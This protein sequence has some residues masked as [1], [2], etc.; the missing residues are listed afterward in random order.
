METVMH[1]KE[2][3]LQLKMPYPELNSIRSLW[4]Q[5]SKD[6]KGSFKGNLLTMLT[7]TAISILI[8]FFFTP[9]I[10]RL[11]TPDMYG[12]FS[13]FRAVSTN[14]SLL[15]PLGF[16]NALILPKEKDIFNA[17]LKIIII[18]ALSFLVLSYS[19]LGIGYLLNFTDSFQ[20]RMGYWIYF[21]PLF[22][23]VSVFSQVIQSWNARLK[24]FRR[25]SVASVAGILAGKSFTISKGLIA[26]S[27]AGLIIGETIFLLADIIIGLPKTFREFIS[28]LKK[29]SM[30]DLKDVFRSFSNYPKYV[31]PA[32][33]INLFGTQLPIFL[34]AFTQSSSTL[35]QLTFA[36]GIINIP[37][38]LISRSFAPVFLQKLV[39]STDKDDSY[40]A[41]LTSR[42]FKSIF[43]L[44]LL[45]FT[46]LLFFGDFILVTFLGDQ[47]YIAGSVAQILVYAFFLAVCTGPLSVI[48]RVKKRERVYF[49]L[50]T[51]SVVLCAAGY[52]IGIYI[53][54][55]W[56]SIIGM[57]AGMVLSNM[58]QL[59]YFLKMSGIKNVAG[60]LLL[61]LSILALLFVITLWLN[62]FPELYVI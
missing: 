47:W 60:S 61:P 13:F 36:L 7:G 16:V 25:R 43:F 26:S 58:I 1:L 11:Y 27:T 48:Y 34:V 28:S 57:S 51:C 15:V 12:E 22:V 9:V 50:S 30:E 49:W 38:Q 5:L 62:L 55:F 24:R 40:I 56:G 59:Y 52:A 46:L 45:P 31:L 2:L 39:E 21:L 20:A 32:S 53:Q 35:G 44:G 14:L 6:W 33:Y 19:Y 3:Y 18:L 29:Y 54:D 23:V 42:F 4:N 17:L 8:S 37:V 10:S 41:R